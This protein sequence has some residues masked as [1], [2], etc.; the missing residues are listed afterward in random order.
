MTPDGPTRRCVLATWAVRL[1][2]LP[3]RAYRLLWSPWVGQ[4]CRFQPTCSSYAIE[5]LERHGPLCGTWLT[6]R[7]LM[8][9]HPWGGAGYDPVPPPPAPRLPR[10]TPE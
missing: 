6:L 1:L 9:C 4:A 2:K 10:K 5:A 3:V 8:R 7:R